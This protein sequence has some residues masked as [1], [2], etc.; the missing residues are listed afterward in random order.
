MTGKSI[1][2]WFSAIEE[3][4]FAGQRRN[5]IAWMYDA[6]GKDAWWPT[7]VWVEYE[8]SKGIVQKD[9]RAEGYSICVTKTISAPLAQVYSAWGGAVFAKWFGDSGQSDTKTGGKITD[10]HGNGGEYLRVRED[11]DL[12][13]SWKTEGRGDQ[14]TVDVVISDKG[15]GKTGLLLNHNRIQSREEAD[16]LRRAWSDAFTALKSEL[17]TAR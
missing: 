16:G 7:T 14:T 9:G 6:M 13:F 8:K 12:R 5:A 15:N 11:K 1:N 4:G 2:E 17:E 3:H 10:A